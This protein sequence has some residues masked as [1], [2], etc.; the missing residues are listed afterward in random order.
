MQ[1]RRGLLISIA[2]LAAVA[3]ALCSF[4]W[5][6][7]ANGEVAA[8]C[9]GDAV[10]CDEVLGSTWSRWLSLPVSL[11]AAILYASLAATAGYL[12]STSLVRRQAAAWSWLLAGSVVAAGAGAWFTGLQAFDLQA[13]CPF[14][15]TVHACGT[16][17]AGMSLA[18]FLAPS[19]GDIAGEQDP[20]NLVGASP[21]KQRLALQS[22]LGGA[23]VLALFVAGHVVFRPD[24]YRVVDFASPTSAAS[25]P[26]TEIGQTPAATTSEESFS[27]AATS[28][29]SGSNAADPAREDNPQK[30]QADAAATEGEQWPEPIPVLGGKTTIDV[31]AHPLLGSRGAEHF[32]VK[33]FDYTCPHCR[34]MHWRLEDARRRYGD[35]LAVVLVP[36]PLNAGCNPAVETNA[37][38]HAFSCVYARLALAVWHARPAAFAA[39]H[40]LL[41]ESEEVPPPGKARY[42]ATKILGADRLDEII[43]GADIAADLERSVELYRLTDRG[44]IPKLILGDAVAEGDAD[45]S[46][47]LYELLEKHLPLQTPPDE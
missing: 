34:S 29:P 44:R 9:G 25:L 33:L 6:G 11:P 36:V 40:K 46:A 27:A 24:S 10:A 8:G 39:F 13:F 21:P 42:E 23:F 43:A 28:T 32:V 37:P 17:I 15:L 35:R 31:Q 2:G 4:L 5:L 45:T 3:A 18:A 22:A 38:G 19:T 20:A 1:L 47:D 7:A 41:I 30:Q 26:D 14:C 12:A 16:A